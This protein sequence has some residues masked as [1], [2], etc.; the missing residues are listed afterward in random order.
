MSLETDD[1]RN[2]D[3]PVLYM[4]QEG[5]QPIIW[6]KNAASITGTLT[7]VSRAIRAQFPDLHKFITTNTVEEKGITFIDNPAKIDYLE[8]A[9]LK[10]FDAKAFTYSVAKPCPPTASKA[11]ALNDD[12]T[13][14]GKTTY[15]F[16]TADKMTD[17][18][19]KRYSLQSGPLEKASAKLLRALGKIFAVTLQTKRIYKAAE[20]DGRATASSS[21][22]S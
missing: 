11:K 21:S 16:L 17:Q 10:A 5:K 3:I 12:L 8:D 4:D 6:D 7:V 15:T 14:A 9:K 20:G 18:Q 22:S 2:A 1:N 13:A 19:R